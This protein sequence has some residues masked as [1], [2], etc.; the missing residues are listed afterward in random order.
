MEFDRKPF[1]RVW[2]FWGDM[3]KIVLTFPDN[4]KQEYDAGITGKEIVDRIGPGLAR[5]AVAVRMDDTILDLVTPLHKSGAFRV[6]TER[7]QEA[8]S[9]L[10]HSCAHV[11]AHAV[12][13]LYPDTK[14]GIGPNVDEGF[15]YD[16]DIGST[17]SPEDLGKIEQEMQ[18]I[19]K[20]DLPFTRKAVTKQEARDIFRNQP[21]KLELLEELGDADA[22]VYSDGDFVDLCR[23][24]HIPRTGIIK[25][26]KLTKVAGAY[27]RADAANKQLQ[28]VYGIAFFKKQDLDDYLKMF[29][30]AEKRDHRKLGQDL[31]LFSMHEEAPGMPFFHHKGQVIVRELTAFMTSEMEKRGYQIVRTPLIMNKQLWLQSGHW[32]HYRQNMYFSKIDEQDVAVKPMNCPGHILVYKS[33]RHSYRELPLKMGEYGIVHRHELSGVLSGLF[34]VRCFTQDDAHIFCRDDQ[35]KDQIVELIDLVH[36]AYSPF[37]FE[38]RVELSTKPEKAMGDPKRWEIAESA[39]AD[40]LKSKGMEY[41]INAGDGA[42]YGPKIDFHVRDAIGRYWQCGTIQV[43]F[44]MPEKFGMTYEGSDGQQHCPVMLHRAIF[45]SLERFIGILIEHFA[46]KFPLWVSPVQVKVL[47]VADRHEEYAKEVAGIMRTAGLRVEVD[48]RSETIPKKVR[49]AQLEKVNYILVVGD[50]EVEGRT[51]TVRQRDGT[52]VGAKKVDE[53]VNDLVAEVREKRLPGF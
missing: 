8:I 7:D 19:V 17:L 15:Y 12:M 23:G 16:M 22:T 9:V 1:N 39:L 14:F 3:D 33:R 13:R 26:V 47:S 37:G 20:E 46:G 30:E 32:D 21:F 28:R 25:A 27:W 35:M 36:A 24:P 38:Y 48:S 50:Q 45:G 6:L 29:E 41:K 31:E 4:S 18:K 43:D 53:F 42:F 49:N 10:R 40:A 34:R 51:V 44:S 2:R 11:L 5:A 52:V